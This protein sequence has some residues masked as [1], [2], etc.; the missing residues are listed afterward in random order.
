MRPLSIAHS[1][2]Q[3]VRAAGSNAYTVHISRIGRPRGRNIAILTIDT[4]PPPFEGWSHTRPS[5]RRL[6]ALLAFRDSRRD[7]AFGIAKTHGL[8]VRKRPV[9]LERQ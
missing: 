9:T 5:L 8:Q 6:A 7:L 4:A 3:P 1:L 2:P